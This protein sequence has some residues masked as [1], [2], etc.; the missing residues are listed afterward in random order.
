M[1]TITRKD[2]SHAAKAAERLRREKEVADA[3]IRA[4]RRAEQERSRKEFEATAAHKAMTRMDEQTPATFANAVLL[5]FNAIVTRNGVEFLPD[6]KV[7]T[8]LGRLK[9]ANRYLKDQGYPQITDSP[10][11]AV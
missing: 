1:E 5:H 9:A 2:R 10:D 4:E 11:W 8:Q 7:A 3:A 6:G